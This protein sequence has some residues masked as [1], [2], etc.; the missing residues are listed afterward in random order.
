MNNENLDEKRKEL[1]EFERGKIIGLST[2]GCSVRKI[3]KILEIPKSTVQNT[4]K[5]F[6]ETGT[7]QN[8]F[9]PGR[10][11]ILTEINK[12]QLKKIVQD[13]PHAT[14]SQI[15]EKFQK[16]TDLSTCTKTIKREI[17]NLGFS[18]CI[19][20]HKPLLNIKQKQNR[21]SWCI[22]QRDW[23]IRKWKN[24]IW[25]DESRFCIFNDGPERV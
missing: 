7:T 3:S 13:E 2:E 24:V 19:A 12:Q 8:L 23:T 5:K 16:K 18:S 22:E 21:L 17:H 14:L 20:A 15:H 6:S 4:I 1:N 9:R 11:R 10:P 25:S